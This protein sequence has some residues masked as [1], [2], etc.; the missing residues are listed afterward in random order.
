MLRRIGGSPPAPSS[1]RRP[2]SIGDGGGLGY[3]NARRKFGRA[4]GGGAIALTAGP[5]VIPVRAFTSG[6]APGTAGSRRVRTM[7]RLD[8]RV[9]IDIADVG[10]GLEPRQILLA[11]AKLSACTTIQSFAPRYFGFGA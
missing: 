3:D 4:A 1:R 7:D 11:Q 10:F 2:V 5:S 8:R 9:D 6:A